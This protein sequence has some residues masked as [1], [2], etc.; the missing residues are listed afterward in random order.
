MWCNQTVSGLNLFFHNHDTCLLINAVPS[1]VVF[2]GLYS[3]GSATVPP[4]KAFCKVHCLQLVKCA[5]DFTL[6]MV[7][8]LNLLLFNNTQS[9]G[10][11]NRIHHTTSGEQ[12]KC[13]MIIICCLSE[14]HAHSKQSEQ[15][16][17][18]SGVQI[19]QQ[20][21]TCSYSLSNCSELT[22]EELPKCQKIHS[23]CILSF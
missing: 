3:V 4:F 14:I 2:L 16:H 6:V 7:M 20:L 21:K 15:M 13:G 12:G 22:Q 18:H 9:F 19:W 10:K 1:E 11:G 17:C 5:L 8:S 23:K